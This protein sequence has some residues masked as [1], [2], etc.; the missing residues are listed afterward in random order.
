MKQLRSLVIVFYINLVILEDAIPEFY[1]PVNFTLTIFVW[2]EAQTR[3][4]Y[5]AI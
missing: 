5:D 4:N 3:V 1:F 2:S